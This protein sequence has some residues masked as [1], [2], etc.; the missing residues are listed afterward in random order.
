MELTI[1]C[2]CRLL[3]LFGKGFLIKK[4]GIL[5][6]EAALTAK[7]IQAEHIRKYGSAFEGKKN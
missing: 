7:G 1:H 5:I 3:S 2:T 4:W 6:S